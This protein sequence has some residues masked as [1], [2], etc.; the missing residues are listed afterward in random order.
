LKSICFL[1]QNTLDIYY[2]VRYTNGMENREFLLDCA[3]T[4]FSARGYDAVGIQEIVDSAGVTKPTLYHYFSHKRGLLDALLSSQFEMLLESVRTTAYYRR[5]LPNSLEKITRAYFQ[6]AI[7]NPRFFRLQLI[8]QYAPKESEPNQ[9][10]S[11]F[12]L[13]QQ[14][15]LQSL[16]I[17]AVQ[18]HGNMRG[19]HVMYAATFLGMIHTYIGEYLNGVTTLEDPLTY[20]AVHQFS[21][22]IYS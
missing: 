6:A 12:R 22:G 18:D 11:P 20:L 5:D 19:R 2:T 15:I 21:H 8:L 14:Q 4:L 16:F 13:E 1:I 7:E 3:L 9:A 17:Q 10:V